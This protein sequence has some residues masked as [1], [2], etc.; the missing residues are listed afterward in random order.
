MSMSKDDVLAAFELA[1]MHVPGGGN[2]AEIECARDAVI[3]LYSAEEFYRSE[4]E[5]YRSKIDAIM[6]EVTQAD[7]EGRAFMSTDAIVAIVTHNTA[8]E[9]EP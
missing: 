9:Q 8:M 7:D 6:A 5:I 4:C 1:H 3:E 2:R